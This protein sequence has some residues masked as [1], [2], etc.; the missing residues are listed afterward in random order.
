MVQKGIHVLRVR[1]RYIRT[2]YWPGPTEVWDQLL[3]INFGVKENEL[4]RGE[5]SVMDAVMGQDYVDSLVFILE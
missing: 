4:S 1:Q 2:H 5:E 3:E